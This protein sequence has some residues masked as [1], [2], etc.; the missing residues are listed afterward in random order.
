MYL[1]VSPTDVEISQ[2]KE[3]RSLARLKE[4]AFLVTGVGMV[5][6][7]VSLTS[8][9]AEVKTRT[10]ELHPEGII[11]FGICGAYLNSG[12]D[13]LDFCLADT[14]QFGDFGIS[15]NNEIEYFPQGV[16]ENQYNYSLKNRLSTKIK[17]S[18]ASLQIPFKN[19]H[20]VTVNACTGTQ[21]R[22]DFLHNK[23]NAVCENMEGAALARVCQLHNIPLA[24]LRCV[25]NLVENRDKS[26]WKIEEAISKGSDVLAQVL[27][28]L[29]NRGD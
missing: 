14:E 28:E 13:L 27:V 26:K 17:A 25:S 10:L 20:F 6:S 12:V 19:G 16:F 24:E 9:L 7:A 29:S 18:L 2:I 1:I 21:T 8:F 3:N 4:F 22:G 23:F 11:L 5:E 15:V